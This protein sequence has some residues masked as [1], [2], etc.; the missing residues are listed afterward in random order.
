MA[1]SLDFEM[2]RVFEH[3][4]LQRFGSQVHHAS[5]S[6]RGS[7]LMLA[8]F[9]HSLFRLSE[10]NVALVLQ[11]CLGGHAPFFH[12]LEVS[13]NHSRFLV[14]CKAVGFHVYALRRIIGKSLISTS[15][16]GAMVP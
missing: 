9:H 7:F 4:V 14:S 6:S 3:R 11:S 1:A 5:P 15:I 13:H 2:G 16:S 8:T 12:V 10:E